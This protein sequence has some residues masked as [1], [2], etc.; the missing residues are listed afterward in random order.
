MAVTPSFIERW[1]V[2][3]G[4]ISE[5]PPHPDGYALPVLSTHPRPETWHDV[6]EVDPQHWPAD[7]TKALSGGKRKFVQPRYPHQ[8]H[9]K[10]AVPPRKWFP[11]MER[12]LLSTSRRAIS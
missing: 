11:N 9:C 12:L 3:L 2:Q 8:L 10:P 7:A 4:L 6:V 1:A 5:T